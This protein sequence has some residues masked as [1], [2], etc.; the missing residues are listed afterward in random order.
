[1]YLLLG[2]FLKICLSQINNFTLID[3][4]SCL[5][6]T[7]FCLFFI[8]NCILERIIEDFPRASKLVRCLSNE[9]LKVNW[10]ERAVF[11]REGFSL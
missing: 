3:F 10:K 9:L 8:F 6:I 5:L 2:A 1:M 7:I 4:L 11:R